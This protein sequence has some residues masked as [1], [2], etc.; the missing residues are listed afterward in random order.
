MRPFQVHEANLCCVLS[1]IGK[2]YDKEICK[3][4]LKDIINTLPR[5]DQEAIA[6]QALL[7]EF[8]LHG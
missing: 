6:I 2:L 3:Q 4:C 1:P 8:T 5:D 7:N